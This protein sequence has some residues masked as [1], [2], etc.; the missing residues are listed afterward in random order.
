MNKFK[1]ATLASLSLAAASAPSALTAEAQAIPA[2]ATIPWTKLGGIPGGSISLA[3]APAVG[4]L[5]GYG[6]N[7]GY[8]FQY[9][10]APNPGTVVQSTDGGTT[11][12]VVDQ[13]I[14]SLIANFSVVSATVKT[15]DDSDGGGAGNAFSA[16]Y[17]N[18]A[19]TVRATRQALSHDPNSRELSVDRAPSRPPLN[20][21]PAPPAPSP[22]PGTR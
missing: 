3:S 4:R 13:P 9:S 1:A 21:R 6:Y 16:P 15:L 12:S 22:S 20:R 14:Q 11:W 5:F 17:A 18:L 19:S 7:S 2:A 10:A 8:S